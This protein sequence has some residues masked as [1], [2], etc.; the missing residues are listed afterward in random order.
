MDKNVSQHSENQQ[1]GVQNI[2]KLGIFLKILM[3]ALGKVLC[4]LFLHQITVKDA[5]TAIKNY[6]VQKLSIL[7]CQGKNLGVETSLH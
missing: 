3:P 2:Q 7:E 4:A 5:L 1:N 6:L